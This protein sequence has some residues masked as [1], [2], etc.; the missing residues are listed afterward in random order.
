[1][2]A[3]AAISLVVLTATACSSDDDPSATV[4]SSIDGDG[5]SESTTSV[6]PVD[7]INEVVVGDL[8][9]LFLNS[10]ET[11]TETAC[12]LEAAASDE[13]LDLT[14]R[15]LSTQ[16][17]GFNQDRFVSLTT[18]L[19]GCS[20][21]GAMTE[22]LRGTV[23][24]GS[25]EQTDEALACF[26]D[27]LEATDGANTYVGLA[28][29]SLQFEVPV[30]STD[31]AV[32]AL[33]NCVSAE[34]LGQGLADSWVS[35]NQFQ[36]TTDAA[37]VADDFDDSFLAAYWPAV[38]SQTGNVEGL[39]EILEGCSE[40]LV[41]D[42]EP[43]SSASELAEVPA[44]ARNAIYDAPPP[45]SVSP[46]D[47]LTAIFKTDVGDIEVRLFTA[48][49]PDTVNNFVS[50]A[51]DG[52]Y[53]ETIFHRVLA[54]FMAQAGDPTGTGSGGPGYTFEDEESALTPIDGR[55]ILAMANSGPDTNGSQF[56]ITF[57]AAEHLNGLHAVFGE[58]IAGDDVLD[59]ILLRDPNNP[60]AQA[61]TLLTVEIVDGEPA[62]PE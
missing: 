16:G 37:C 43:W 48:E 50:L 62:T 31:P 1:M 34:I 40:D 3:L 46:D 45:S 23:S 53:D 25:D 30:D 22:L 42:H 20:E 14:L 8:T 9:G 38:V 24:S 29:V 21:P 4:D 5:A 47:A 7:D 39:S 56:F 35:N 32:D 55:G 6:E 17:V 61:T 18:A 44:P 10:E 51:R 19:H 11:P 49:A 41:I 59:E 28:A 13:A 54:G 57:D 15:E 52:F 60:N 12:I 33:T 2:K 36:V 27:E 58:V 26:A